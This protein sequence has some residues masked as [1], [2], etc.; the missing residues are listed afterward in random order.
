MTTQKQNKK[1]FFDKPENYT[2]LLVFGLLG[3]A[4]ISFLD[5][6]LP[7]VNRVLD[8]ALET[9]FKTVGLGLALAIVT[10]VVTSKDL[11][12]VA[13]LAYDLAMKK[14]T[15]VF[16]TIDPILVKEKYAEKLEGDLA[17]MKESI[18]HL[19][20]KKRDLKNKLENTTQQITA[21]QQEAVLI[22]KKV[23]AGD[24]HMKG[25]FVLRSRRIGRQEK[26]LVT[27]K[28][29]YAQISSQ[30]AMMEKIHEASVIMCQDLRES[31]IS[32]RERRDAIETSYKLLSSS[33]KFIETTRERELF[34][35]A[36]EADNRDYFEKLGEIE[37]FMQDSQELITTTDLQNGL[38]E[39]SALEKVK[40]WEQRSQKLLS[41]TKFRVPTGVEE[42]DDEIQTAVAQGRGM[43]L[44]E[45]L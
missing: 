31:V 13:W 8:F 25:Q 37:Q 7:V 42:I 36:V 15:N 23:A 20:G 22:N 26:T 2:K 38:Y 14:L 3:W 17:S 43:S 4:G 12:K 34:D 19:R 29:L 39:A 24:E 33:R 44:F 11:H 6:V 40:D 32:D 45:K 10:W 9:T 18:G 35:M 16:V 5:Q 27:Y 21:T 30:L 41:D 1:G 28:E